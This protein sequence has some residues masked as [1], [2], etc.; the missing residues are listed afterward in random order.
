MSAPATRAGAPRALVTG[1]AGQDGS[2]LTELLL[3]RGYEVFGV[4]RAPKARAL[5]N[6]EHVRDRI[7]L[8]EADLAEPGTLAAALAEVEPAELYHLAAPTF[9]PLSWQDPASTVS[10]IAVATAALLAQA[11]ALDPA[12]R[13][14]VATSSEIFGEAGESPQN[15]HTPCRPTT[16]YGVAKLAAHLLVG[17]LREHHGLHACSGITYNHESPR[18]PERFVTRKV[19]RAA[20]AIKLGIEHEVVLGDLD[21]IRDWSDAGDIVRGAWLMLRSD[22]ADDYVLASGHGR[23]VRELVGVAFGCV[24]LDPGRHVRVDPSLLRPEPGTAPVGDPA[25]ARRE[26]GWSPETSF[27]QMIEAMVEADL[28]RLREPAGHRRG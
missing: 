22:R 6:L 26:L 23:T 11:R 4:V 28:E 20:A 16:P 25:K 9:V 10:E 21:A 15:E 12:P 13:V 8:L 24:G 14:Y 17:T 1:A 5:P 27:E 2:Y 19:T 18:R 7:T 3:D